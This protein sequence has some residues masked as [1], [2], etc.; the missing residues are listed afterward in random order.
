[1]HPC[2]L[3]GDLLVPLVCVVC[4]WLLSPRLMMSRTTFPVVRKRST[5]CML[6]LYRVNPETLPV[7]ACGRRRGRGGGGKGV[8]GSAVVGLMRLTQD[9]WHVSV[10]FI[11]CA[12]NHGVPFLWSTR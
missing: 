5:I 7:S 2:G 10:C 9:E 3:F 8:L 11:C 6:R 12:L 1:M 4:G